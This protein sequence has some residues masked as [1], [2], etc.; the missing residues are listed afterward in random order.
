MPSRVY[1]Q[2]ALAGSDFVHFNQKGARVIAEM[3][4]NAL[5]YEYEKYLGR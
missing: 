5:Y 1:A 4:Y 3:F 2:P